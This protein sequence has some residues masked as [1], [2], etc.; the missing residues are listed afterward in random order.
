MKRIKKLFDIK[1]KKTKYCTKCGRKLKKINTGI[2]VPAEP[3]HPE[4]PYDG[5]YKNVFLY[6]CNKCDKK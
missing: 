6:F 2:Q 4:D 3:Y 5:Y 1:R